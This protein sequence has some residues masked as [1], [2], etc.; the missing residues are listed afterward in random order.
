MSRKKK[1]IENLSSANLA[2]LEEGLKTG[3]A[4]DFRKRCH[5]ILLSHKGY[6]VSEISEIL[7][8]TPQSIYIWFGK[9]ESEGISGLS[10]KAGQGRPKKLLLSD[11][12]HLAVVKK[13]VEEHAQNLDQILLAIKEALGIEEISPRS[14]RR[15]LKKLVTDG[16][17]FEKV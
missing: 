5:A 15:F 13:A 1:F 2:V 10:R 8:C 17:D 11:P 6:C 9:W 12:H 3:L 4:P 7:S 16:N 14:L